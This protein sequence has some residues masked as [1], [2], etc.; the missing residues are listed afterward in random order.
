[1]PATRLTRAIRSTILMASLLISWSVD[2]PRARAQEAAAPG[3]TASATIAPLA[4]LEKSLVDAIARAERSVVAISRQRRPLGAARP[5]APGERVEGRDEPRDAERVGLVPERTPEDPDFVPQDYATGV[6][7]DRSGLIVTA[8]H[9]LGDV[10]RSRYWVTWQRKPYEATVR[11]AD[12]WLDIAVLKIAADNL[13]PIR[14]GDARTLRRGQFVVALGNPYAIARDGLPSATWGIVSN[15]SRRAPPAGGG[16]ERRAAAGGETLHHYGTLIQTD[17]RLSLGTS[18]GALLNLQGEMIGL[19]TTLA[20]LEGYETSAG[21]AIPVDDVFQRTLE[22]LKAGRKAEYGFLGVAPE[23][24]SL[25]E[26]QAG[27]QGVRVRRA[28]PGTPAAKAGLLPDDLITHVAGTPIVDSTDLIRELSKWPVEAKIQLT[29]Q[30]GVAQRGVPPKPIAVPVELS[31]KH[32]AGTRPPVAETP[33]P[34]WRGL[35][36]DYSTAVSRFESKSRELDP[37]GCVVIA[38]VQRDSPAWN[39]GLRPGAF[40]SHVGSQRVSKPR[41][42]YALV[43]PQAGAVAVRVSLADAKSDVRQIAP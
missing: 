24:L 15:L 30:R 41:E 8:Y 23:L 1:M 16:D 26:R 9:A 31:K 13:E 4:A 12:P 10:A 25:E 32:L 19:T 35:R 38:D 43:E 2:V 22:T 3:S 11:A 37:Q 27:G 34:V 29:V 33:D 40:I 21:F 17:A 6:V 20:A 42:F 36:V 28:V 18:G 39:A 7:V 5:A 14:F